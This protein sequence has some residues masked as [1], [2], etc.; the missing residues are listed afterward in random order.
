MNVYIEVAER[1]T[2][3][4]QV[5]AGF[6]SLERFIATAQVQQANLFGNGQSSS[7]AGSMERNPTAGQFALL[8]AVFPR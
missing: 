8:R 4:F 3:T 1:P 6:S 2:G 7:A 5:G